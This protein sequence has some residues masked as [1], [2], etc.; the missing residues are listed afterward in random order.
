[1]TDTGA[2]ESTADAV[3]PMRD[4]DLALRFALELA[5]LGALAYWGVH[6][7]LSVAADVI[8]GVG[9]PVM[10]AVVWGAFAAPKSS[11]R[12]SGAA[13]IAVQLAV[14][15]AGAIA[16]VAAGQP[17]LGAAFAALIGANTVLLHV[18]GGGQT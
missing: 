15:G 12:L 16:L 13:L 1:M 4:T 18:L 2:Q 17:V 8:L 6:T 10:A 3:G 11:R 7:G 14:L 9:A 5:A